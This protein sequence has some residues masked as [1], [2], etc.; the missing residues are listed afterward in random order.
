MDK[1]IAIFMQQMG[2]PAAKTKS[3]KRLITYVQQ[4]IFPALRAW[5][6]CNRGLVCE[7]SMTVLCSVDGGR[8]T[9]DHCTVLYFAV[10]YCIQ[11]VVCILIVQYSTV[12]YCV[13]NV[14][15]SAGLP[16]E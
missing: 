3:S 16:A 12:L 4:H 15:S 14:K 8:A 13:R 10:L 9:S 2:T 1:L 7:S 6:S 11:T 5:F